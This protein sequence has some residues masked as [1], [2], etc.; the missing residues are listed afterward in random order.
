[1]HKSYISFSSNDI[2]QIWRCWTVNWKPYI[3]HY[4]HSAE[5]R[6]KFKVD[7]AP[8]VKYCQKKKKSE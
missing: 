5:N 2:V 7:D 8:S 6:R 4:K 1:M 3:A